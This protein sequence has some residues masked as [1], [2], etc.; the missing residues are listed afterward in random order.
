MQITDLSKRFCK[1]N[2]FYY[3]FV[4]LLLTNDYL[5]LSNSA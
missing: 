4:A 5:Q 2:Y 3:K 1:L